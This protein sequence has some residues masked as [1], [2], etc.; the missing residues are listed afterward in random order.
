LQEGISRQQ[1]SSQ[2]GISEN[3]KDASC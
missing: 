2:G 3:K 1:I